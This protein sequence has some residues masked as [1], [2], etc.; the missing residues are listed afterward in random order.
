[1][2]RP[3]RNWLSHTRYPRLAVGSL[4]NATIF[5]GVTANTNA[6]PGDWLSR[7]TPSPTWKTQSSF[8]PLHL[9]EPGEHAVVAD[10]G[11]RAP[12]HDI[13][14]GAIGVG[15]RGEQ[16]TGLASMFFASCS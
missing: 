14:P 6:T 1:M 3:L 10:P 2:R 7:K 5:D 16:A 8:V 4:G 13:Q 15:A 12:D 9:P 11:D